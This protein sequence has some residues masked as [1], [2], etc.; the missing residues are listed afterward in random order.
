MHEHWVLS[1]NGVSPTTSQPSG[2]R[3]LIKRPNGTIRARVSYKGRNY[4]RVFATKERAKRWRSQMLAD[5]ARCPGG[6]QSV[7]NLWVAEVVHPGGV[8]G[9]SFNLLDDAIEWLTAVKTEIRTGHF[10]DEHFRGCTLEDFIP[11]WKSTKVRASERTMLRYE[12][13]LENQ[14]LPT[15]G[16]QKLVNISNRI[17]GVWCSTLLKQS[18]SVSNVRKAIALVKH[19]LKQAE[20]AG[21]ISRAPLVSVE[22]PPQNKKVQRAL[23]H[24]EL[25]ELAKKCGPYEDFVLLLGTLGLRIGEARALTVADVD[26]SK[27]ELSVSKSFTIDGNYR[28]AMGPTKSRQNRTIPIPAAIHSMLLQ[29]TKGKLP[30]AWLFTGARGEPLSDGWFRKRWFNPAIGTLGL[31][32]ITIHNLRHTCASLLIQQGTQITTV[33]RIL[34]H[35]TVTQTLNTYGHYYQNDLAQSLQRLDETLSNVRTA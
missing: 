23:T 10:V 30:S 7:R 6:I 22:L 18:T 34:G 11:T 1:R 4:E 13:L 2:D 3:G 24:F 15:L 19:I 17:V 29:R 16:N 33:S 26:L 25:N 35:S 21:A 14:I 20:I 12:D 27:R 31:D 32:G 28:R 9:E 8:A 5:L